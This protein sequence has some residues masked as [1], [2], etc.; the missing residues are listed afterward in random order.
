MFFPKVDKNINENFEN[1]VFWEFGLDGEYK[2]I[3]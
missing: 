2:M 3:G 1:N